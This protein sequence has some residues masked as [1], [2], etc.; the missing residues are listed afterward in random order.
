MGWRQDSSGKALVQQEQGPDFKSQYD[1]KKLLLLLLFSI[2][3]MLLPPI[4]F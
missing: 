2:P 1:Q 3:Y 4:K